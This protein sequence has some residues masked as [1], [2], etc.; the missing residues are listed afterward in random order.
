MQQGACGTLH[1]DFIAVCAA[2]AGTCLCERMRWIIC[3][4][5]YGRLVQTRTAT[6]TAVAITKTKRESLGCEGEG[7]LSNK[8]VAVFE[9]Q[10]SPGGDAAAHHRPEQ[11]A[12]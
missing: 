8:I 4:V 2:V 7:I 6:D 9:P 3:A 5:S 11:Q 10:S 1:G 12:P